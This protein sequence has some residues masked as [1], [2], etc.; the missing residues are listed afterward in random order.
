MMN[1]DGWFDNKKKNG[2]KRKT[3][4]DDYVGSYRAHG[5]RLMQ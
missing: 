3:I 2:I 1:I 5:T 4:L